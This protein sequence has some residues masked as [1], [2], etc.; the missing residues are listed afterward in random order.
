MGLS[1]VY[2]VGQQR[3]LGIALFAARR[4]IRRREAGAGNK[5]VI[6]FQY[7]FQ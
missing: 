7:S 4:A 2:A 6:I 1:A 3:E 5:L